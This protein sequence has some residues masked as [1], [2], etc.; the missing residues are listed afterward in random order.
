MADAGNKLKKIDKK[1]H[2]VQKT[3]NGIVQLDLS[4]AEPGAEVQLGFFGG[5]ECA[6]LRTPGSAQVVI[7]I[8][9]VLVERSYTHLQV[10][11]VV[12][13]KFY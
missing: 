1:H 8:V 12:Y 13:Y 9:S 11:L 10:L 6:F 7:A 4:Q 3:S 2:V 5:K